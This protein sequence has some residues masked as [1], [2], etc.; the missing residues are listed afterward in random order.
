LLRGHSAGG[1][2]SY[3]FS[4]VYPVST[5]AWAN[6]KG[7]LTTSDQSLPPGLFIV[8][9]DDLITRNQS[10]KA[11]FLKQ[12]KNGSISVFALEPNAGH[13][14]GA[15]DPLIRTFFSAILNKTFDAVGGISTIDSNQVLLGNNQTLKFWPYT[16]YPGIKTEASCLI[17]RRFAE[18]WVEFMT[19]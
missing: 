4:Q 13:G 10:I 19:D 9:E 2:F 11:S 14:A 15:S 1:R 16:E 7:S 12:R 8:G 3:D 5:I 17:D 18:A 6:I